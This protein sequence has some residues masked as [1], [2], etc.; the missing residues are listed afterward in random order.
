MN[1]SIN[2]QNLEKLYFSY[3]KEAGFRGSLK[4]LFKRERVRKRAVLPFNFQMKRGEIV[5]F[6][7]PNGAGKSTLI[8]MFTGI[9]V[10]SGGEL[11]VAGHRPHLREI[12][13][14]KKIALV[15]GQ[16]SQLWWDIPAIDSFRLLQRYY[17]IP[18]KKFKERL[19]EL[20]LLLEIE[21]LLNLPLRKLSLG[22]RMKMELI[23]SLLHDPE[24]LFLD[25][26]TIGLDLVSQEK[27]RTFFRSYKERKNI[28]IILTSHYMN[29]IEALCERVVL[30]FAGEKIFD[31][32]IAEIN[33]LIE[34]NFG[35]E[36]E[37]LKKSQ[38]LEKLMHFLMEKWKDG[39]IARK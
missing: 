35:E 27:I 21:D 9:V 29:D 2:C 30:I 1:Y 22:E 5:A 12:S 36:A 25:E 34:Q 31:S 3:R 7:G 26:P 6:I 33:S 23:A 18:K 4:S 19:D 17:E 8:K 39:K 37:E 16:K 24:I 20:A 32:K 10:P 38:S 13:F 28:S 15:M 14:R 11:E